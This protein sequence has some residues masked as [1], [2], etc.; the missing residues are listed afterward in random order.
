VF[1]THERRSTIYRPH[2]QAVRERS[3]DRHCTTLIQAA[4]GRRK[5]RPKFVSVSCIGVLY[6]CLVS[7]SCIGVLYRCLVSVSCLGVLSRC[8]V[9]ASY[10][11]VLSW[12]LVSVSY[13]C[14]L[15]CLVLS[16]L[17]VVSCLRVSSCLVFLSHVFVP[18][19]ITQRKRELKC[20]S[21][22][23]VAM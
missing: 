7:V 6:R 8:L 15:S 19:M 22:V 16:C 9:S 11:G 10:L 20:C 4:L 1:Q 5:K 2:R 14:V 13:L 17:G 3:A 23:F 21:V 12:C 18:W